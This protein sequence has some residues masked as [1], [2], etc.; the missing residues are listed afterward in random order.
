MKQN[1]IEFLWEDLEE[2]SDRQIVEA[3]LDIIKPKQLK[4]LVKNLKENY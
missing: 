4:E 2:F 1:E 3:V